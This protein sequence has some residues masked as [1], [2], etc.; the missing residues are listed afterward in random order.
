MGLRQE[1]MANL[2]EQKTRPEPERRPSRGKE[3]CWKARTR[4]EKEW[5]GRR[6]RVG[7]LRSRALFAPGPALSLSDRETPPTTQTH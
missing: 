1:G 3:R 2:C 6:G 4:W 5:G 7:L